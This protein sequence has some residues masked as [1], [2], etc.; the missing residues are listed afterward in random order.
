MLLDR[1][2]EMCFF[3][4][5]KSSVEVLR[6]IFC[7]ISYSCWTDEMRCVSSWRITHIFSSPYTPN[8]GY[9]LLQY[10]KIWYKVW[11]TRDQTVVT[12]SISLSP[13][14]ALS[15]PVH[16]EFNTHFFSTGTK[17]AGCSSISL[18]ICARIFL[19]NIINY[20]DQSLFNFTP[21]SP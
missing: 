11:H 19:P 20:N 15:Q 5:N 3:L 21:V 18:P 17:L 9:F 7:L 6:H 13:P 16:W 4:N 14:L 10:F 8:Y 12:Y 1:W 2:Y